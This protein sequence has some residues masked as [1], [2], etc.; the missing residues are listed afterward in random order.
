MAFRHILAHGLFFAAVVNA[1]LFLVMV[2]LSPRVWGYTDFPQAVKD[3]VPPQTKREWTLAALIAGPW[4]LFVL[5]FPLFSAYSLKAALG[6]RIPFWTAFLDL[7]VLWLLT[8]LVDLV[9]L[10]WLVV[11]RL[12]PRFVIIPGSEK[13]DYR[14]LSEHYRGHAKGLGLIVLASLAAAAVVSFL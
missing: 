1:Y 8:A 6:G 3:K 14:D 2:L 7:A 10:D 5:A 4:I 12:T 13:A 9:I 11:S